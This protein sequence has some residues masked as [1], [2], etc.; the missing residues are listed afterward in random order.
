MAEKNEVEMIPFL[1]ELAATLSKLLLDP[2]P[3][4]KENCATFLGLLS[5]KLKTKLGHHARPIL[6][7]LIKNTKHQRLRIRRLSLRAIGDVVKTD[8]A[9][10][11]LKDILGQLKGLLNDKIAEVRK[12]LH[13]IVKE[14]LSNFDLSY[15][16]MFEGDLIMILLAGVGDENKEIAQ[17]CVES[18]DFYGTNLR[19]L[20]DELK[21]DTSIVDPN[22]FDKE[23]QKRMSALQ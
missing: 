23:F 1:S 2:N 22:S 9:P 18:L 17:L 5:T 14:W 8:H 4:M 21:E 19:K 6:S 20:L 12:E 11:L 16:K 15:L 3:T 13:I 7:S 10:P